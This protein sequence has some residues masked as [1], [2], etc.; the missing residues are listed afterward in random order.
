MFLYK[1]I[2]EVLNSMLYGQNSLFPDAFFYCLEFKNRVKE[3]YSQEITHVL[4]LFKCQ[5]I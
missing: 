5:K 4:F 2:T 1:Q 3:L